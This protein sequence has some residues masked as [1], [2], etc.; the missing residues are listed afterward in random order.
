[1]KGCVKSPK[2]LGKVEKAEFSSPR[3]HERFWCV[4]QPFA[5]THRKNLRLSIRVKTYAFGI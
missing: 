3:I 4:L 2:D 1:M 5:N